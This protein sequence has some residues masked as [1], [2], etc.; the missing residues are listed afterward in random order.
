MRL[1][2]IH[3]KW[4]CAILPEVE[5][6]LKFVVEIGVLLVRIEPGQG[7]RPTAQHLYL[8]KFQRYY[9][10]APKKYLKSLSDSK[11]ICHHVE[12]ST[13]VKNAVIKEMLI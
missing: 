13:V 8:V 11:G 12:D 7:C 6:V 2:I 3:D 9:A 4:R 10:E 5:C 1:S